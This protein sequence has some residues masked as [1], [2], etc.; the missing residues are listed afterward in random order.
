M[1]YT[2]SHLLRSYKAGALFPLLCSKPPQAPTHPLSMDTAE[3]RQISFS[4]L[5][6][7]E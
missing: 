7:H 5:Y 4:P 3:Q 6:P 1:E 2:Q